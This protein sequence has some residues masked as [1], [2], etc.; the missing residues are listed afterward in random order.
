LKEY[1]EA[2]KYFENAQAMYKNNQYLL[3]KIKEIKNILKK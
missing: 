3:Q 2:L 1:E